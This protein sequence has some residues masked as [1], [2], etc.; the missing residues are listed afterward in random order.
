MP[1]LDQKP[2]GI[3]PEDDFASVIDAAASEEDRTSHAY[4]YYDVAIRD[5]IRDTVQVDGR[6]I[7]TIQST[8]MRAFGDMA[9]M[10]KKENP[11]EWQRHPLDAKAWAKFP[12]PFAIFDRTSTKW[13]QEWGNTKMPLRNLMFL[14]EDDKRRTAHARPPRPMDYEYQIDVFAMFEKHMRWIMQ[15]L[16]EEFFPLAYYRIKT[17]FSGDST[18]AM[19]MKY[20]GWTDNSDLEPGNEGDRLLRQT[21]T[22]TVEGWQWFDLKKAPTVQRFGQISPDLEES[23][24]ALTD[25]APPMTSDQIN[26]LPQQPATDGVAGYT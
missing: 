13:R 11:D 1:K 9:E 23:N 24:T 15:K 21:L 2:Y 25:L 14:N 17:P 22:L 4:R 5:W 12:L 7:R 3:P 10:L 6:A 18:H 20:G 19:A 8:P 16:E 26:E